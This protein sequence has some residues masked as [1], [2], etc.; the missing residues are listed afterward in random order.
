VVAGH[1]GLTQDVPM[2]TTSR[3]PKAGQIQQQA[4]GATTDHHKLSRTEMNVLK[5]MITVIVVFVLFWT[6][7]AFANLFLLLGVSMN[8]HCVPKNATLFMF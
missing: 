6:V 2:A 3:D 8:T 5:T 7:P 1:A 4:T